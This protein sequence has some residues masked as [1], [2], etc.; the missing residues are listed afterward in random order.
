MAIWHDWGAR[1]LSLAPAESAH[2]M[3]IKL[4]AQGYGPRAAMPGDPCLKTEVAG[5]SFP[6]P[7]GLA[8]GFD[9]NAEAPA[10]CLA[11][12]FGFVEIGAVTPR[13]QTGNPQPRVFRLPA[14]RAVI[15]R[16]GFNN[17]GLEV[18]RAR[19]VGGDATWRDRRQSWG[20]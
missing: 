13:P 12:G 4:L 10:A 1:A 20:Q 18:V 15:N 7:L 8:A 14:D 2:K 3:T 16:M 17:E 6:N 5:I 11:M 9:K 19:L